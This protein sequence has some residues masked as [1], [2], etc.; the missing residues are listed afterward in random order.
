MCG[1]AKLEPKLVPFFVI[2]NQI[3]YISLGLF[4]SLLLFPVSGTGLGPCSSPSISQ[5]HQIFSEPTSIFVWVLYSFVYN[6][7]IYLYSLITLMYKISRNAPLATGRVPL[8][9][10]YLVSNSILISL[11]LMMHPG[12]VWLILCLN[13]YAEKLTKL[14]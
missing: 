9:A 3:Y 12:N 7:C 6:K 11:V 10:Q 1:F 2:D 5:K 8:S 13:W 4:D 14:M